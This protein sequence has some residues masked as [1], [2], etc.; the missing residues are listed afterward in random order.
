MTDYTPTFDGAT[1][2]AGAATAT[3]ADLD[4]DFSDIETAIGTKINSIAA[5]GKLVSLTAAGD[6][7]SSGVPASYLT[8]LT[9]NLNTQLGLLDKEDSAV[10]NFR[11][12]GSVQLL[13][14][15]AWG[16]SVPSIDIS[17]LTSGTHNKYYPTGRD[18]GG[19]AWS[20]LDNIP[21]D[22]YGLLLEYRGQFTS[23]SGLGSYGATLHVYPG[24]IAD[25]TND[26]YLRADMHRRKDLS[27]RTVKFSSG[28]F[29]VPLHTT[30]AFKVCVTL[31]NATHTAGK[32]ILRGFAHE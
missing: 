28:Q 31:T 4:Q 13:D 30:Q 24:D 12:G 29:W 20:D 26:S 16:A 10:S 17:G 3:A 7:Q 8:G 15:D 25:S 23:T 11:V 14:W 18:T 22:A 2:D 19:T 6:I 5:E 27:G 32:L 21:T 1:E 9:S